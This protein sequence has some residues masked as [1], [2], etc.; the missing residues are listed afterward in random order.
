MTH[1][2]KILPEYF[3]AV[4]DGIKTFEIRKNDRDFKVRD[5]IVLREWN[6]DYTGRFYVGRISY[7]IDNP[8]YVKDGYVVF[9]F[10]KAP[11]KWKLVNEGAEIRAVLMCED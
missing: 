7:I 5:F 9:S 2:L 1:V 11:H 6:G 3:E 10:I 4:K 8:E